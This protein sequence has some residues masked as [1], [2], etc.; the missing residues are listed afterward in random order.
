MDGLAL[1]NVHIN[2]DDVQLYVLHGLRKESKDVCT[3]V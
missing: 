3:I 1:V 2:D